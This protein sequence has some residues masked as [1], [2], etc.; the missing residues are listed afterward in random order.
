VELS[1]VKNKEFT[2]PYTQYSQHKSLIWSSNGYLWHHG[3]EA[4]KTFK[5]GDVIKFKIKNDY[6]T[7]KCGD[8]KIKRKV[9]LP[10]RPCVNLMYNSK[11]E[12]IKF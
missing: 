6:L 7:I 2:W 3:K 9:N 4:A 12:S 10:V 1:R 8:T 11:I 5:T